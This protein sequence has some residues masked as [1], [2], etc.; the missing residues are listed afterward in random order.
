MLTSSVQ[1]LAFAYRNG[2]FSLETIKQQQLWFIK[3]ARNKLWDCTITRRLERRRTDP[4]VILF[5]VRTCE[6]PKEAEPSLSDKVGNFPQDN[7]AIH[8][9]T[10]T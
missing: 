9:I 3:R 1:K 4:M 7:A 8:R 5:R 2:L 6:V 10:V